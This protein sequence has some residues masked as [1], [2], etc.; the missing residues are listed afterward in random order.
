MTE[1]LVYAMPQSEEASIK[2]FEQKI[3]RKHPDFIAREIE[4]ELILISISKSQADMECVYVLNGVGARIWQFIDG[5]KAV[6]EI[7]KLISKQYDARLEDIRKD[8]ID[9]IGGLE[10]IF[11]IQH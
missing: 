2:E 11:A 4:G 6:T 5:H 1:S 3:F 10:T 7:I 8:V 9:F